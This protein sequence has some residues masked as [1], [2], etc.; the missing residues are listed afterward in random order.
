MSNRAKDPNFVTKDESPLG[1]ITLKPRIVRLTTRSGVDIKQ[2]LP[3]RL[4]RTIGAWCF[5]DYFGPTDQLNAMRV[6]AHPHAGLQTVSWLFS[7]G[8]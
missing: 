5:V 2:T 3:H 4:L 7:Q 6:A 1:E 8:R